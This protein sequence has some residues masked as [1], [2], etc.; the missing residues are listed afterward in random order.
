MEIRQEALCKDYENGGLKNVDIIFK[1][2]CLQCSWIKR[3]YDSSTYDW[4][5][6]TLHI[7]TQKLGKHFYFILIYT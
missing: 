4:K 7:I 2:I 5:L 3:L 6:I 1:I